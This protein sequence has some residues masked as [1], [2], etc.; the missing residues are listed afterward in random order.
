ML[1][2]CNVNVSRCN[3]VNSTKN[4]YLMISFKFSLMDIFS[5]KNY[6]MYILIECGHLL[7]LLRRIKYRFMF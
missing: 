1:N 4:T 2:C 3:I 6:V 5:V 7:W